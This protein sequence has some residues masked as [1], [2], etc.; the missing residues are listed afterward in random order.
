VRLVPLPLSLAR[1]HLGTHRLTCHRVALTSGARD[2]AGVDHQGLGMGAH[3]WQRRRYLRPEHHSHTDDPQ[4]SGSNP[5]R[6]DHA[7]DRQAGSSVSHSQSV[8]RRY[9]RS[10]ILEPS[11]R[12]VTE[13]SSTLTVV[14]VVPSGLRTFRATTATSTSATVSA[15]GSPRATC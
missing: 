9:P 12:F 15:S 8:S 13:P 6:V 1:V 14:D 10:S 3:L 5:G 7:S 11:R 2:C 4:R